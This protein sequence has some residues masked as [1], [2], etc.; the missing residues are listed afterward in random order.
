MTASQL[1]LFG[2]F[3]GFILGSAFTWTIMITY[4]DIITCKD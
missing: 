3:Y 1:Q 2:L 4:I